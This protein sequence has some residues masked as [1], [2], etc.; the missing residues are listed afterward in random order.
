MQK[1]KNL[2][3]IDSLINYHFKFIREIHNSLGIRDEKFNKT[4]FKILNLIGNY[5]ILL[6]NFILVVNDIDESDVESILVDDLEKL[7]SIYMDIFN[8]TERFKKIENK[9]Q[10]ILSK[11]Q[12]KAKK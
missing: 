10:I 6:T 4:I 8:F 7:E 12:E 9:I 11:Y 3:S 2:K 5:N 1:I